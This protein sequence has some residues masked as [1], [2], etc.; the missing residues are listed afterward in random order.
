MLQGEENAEVWD[1]FKMNIKSSLEDALT[2]ALRGDF[3]HACAASLE[4]NEPVAQIFAIKMGV[5]AH[6]MTKAVFPPLEELQ[7]MATSLPETHPF[8]GLARALVGLIAGEVIPADYSRVFRDA[9]TQFE[10]A[11]D[12]DHELL[13]FLFLDA[14]T[15]G[16]SEFAKKYIDF[17]KGKSDVVC[18]YIEAIIERNA[19]FD[20][21]Y[22]ITSY[23]AFR[24]ELIIN[25]ML[26]EVQI[27][28]WDKLMQ[29]EYLINYAEITQE[30]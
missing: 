13:G 17:Y 3:D 29:E 18:S 7:R 20:K 8:T 24:D 1:Q 26:D 12:A 19:I 21:L 14:R 2:F 30:N 6:S 9:T 27:L 5:L 28:Y 23:D 4:V 22:S 15:P 10:F 16:F 11:D 25:K